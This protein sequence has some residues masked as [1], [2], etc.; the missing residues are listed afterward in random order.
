[1]T[2]EEA[3]AYFIDNNEK[4]ISVA[5]DENNYNYKTQQVKDVFMRR[6]FEANELAIKALEQK[7]KTGQWIERIERDD[8]D[9]SED[10]WYECDQCH[11]DWGGPVNFCPNCGARMVEPQEGSGKG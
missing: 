11:T 7:P 2:K 6:T 9:D 1:M 8:W 5:K 4:I 10:V 3:R